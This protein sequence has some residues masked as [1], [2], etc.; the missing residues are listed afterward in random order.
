MHNLPYADEFFEA[1]K[2][3]SFNSEDK[4]TPLTATGDTLPS[5]TP[6]PQIFTA[7]EAVRSLSSSLNHPCQINHDAS[8]HGIKHASI[9]VHPE[10]NHSLVKEKLHTTLIKHG[11]KSKTAE[12]YKGKTYLR[13]DTGAKVHVAHIGQ[14]LAITSED[15]KGTI[16]T[17]YTPPIDESKGV[18]GKNKSK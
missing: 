2:K 6:N 14:H 16:P 13:E 5:G 4:S 9:L 17:P 7:Q 3:A 10:W 15:K 11:F 1:V 12:G 18:S 8:T